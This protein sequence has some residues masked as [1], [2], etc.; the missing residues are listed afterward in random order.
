MQR[1]EGGGAGTIKGRR[2]SFVADF[3]EEQ[4]EDELPEDRPKNRP[5][6][7]EK[8]GYCLK[9]LPACSHECR[10]ICHSGACAASTYPF[11]FSSL[12]LF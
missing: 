8:S 10:Q 2:Y 1:L 11:P 6:K 9:T 12:F 3:V 4:L 7:E 5:L